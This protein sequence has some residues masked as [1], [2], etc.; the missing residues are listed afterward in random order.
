[1]KGTIHWVSARHAAR[2][3]IRLYDRLFKVP[4]PDRGDAEFEQHLNPDSLEVLPDAVLEPALATARP[5]EIFQFERQGYFVVDTGRAGNGQPVFS[6][7]VS[8][9]DSW[10]KLE[11]QALQDAKK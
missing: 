10:A 8:L 1:V 7:T 9:R 5:G 2:A 4:S 3:E 6:R 11:K